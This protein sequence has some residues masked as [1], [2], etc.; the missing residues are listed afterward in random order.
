MAFTVESPP[1]QGQ[2]VVLK[3]V[4]VSG[5]AILQVTMDQL[6]CASLFKGENKGVPINTVYKV[7]KGE[8]AYCSL[9]FF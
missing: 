3:V 7:Q 8:Y 2:Q 6:M 1:A 5:A 9:C 4:A